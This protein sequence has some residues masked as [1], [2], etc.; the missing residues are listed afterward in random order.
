MW[1]HVSSVKQ[2]TSTLAAFVALVSIGSALFA[3][4][5][6]SNVI[7]TA[8][9]LAPGQIRIETQNERYGGLHDVNDS[10]NLLS[11]EAGVTPRLQVGLDIHV[12]SDD[13]SYG[14]GARYLF[15]RGTRESPAVAVGVTD[16]MKSSAPTTYAV[17]TTPLGPLRGHL[18][19]TH[20]NGHMFLISGVDFHARDDLYLLCDWTSGP[21]GYLTIGTYQRVGG[22]AWVNVVIGR[23]NDHARRYLLL[24]KLVYLFG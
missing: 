18:G 3:F 2:W 11:I 23:P 8:D 9:V 5:T 4:P 15:V 10:E 7:P 22:D 19:T 1:R 16:V 24:T 17:I 12:L 13:G 21:D 6:S 14:L 20:K